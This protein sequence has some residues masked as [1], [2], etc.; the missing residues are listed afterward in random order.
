MSMRHYLRMQAASVRSRFSKGRESEQVRVDSNLPLNLRFG[1]RLQFSEAPFLLAGEASYVSFP[2]NEALIGAFSEV[3]LGGLK[4]FRLY[5]ESRADEEQSAMLM[6]LMSD[7]GDH[8]D[9]MYLFQEQ[10]ELPIYHVSLAEVA[11]HDDETTAVDFWLKDGEGILGMPL[12]HTPDELTYERLWESEQDRWLKPTE[13]SETI[14]L[15]AYGSARTK[16][17]HVGS[18][19]FGRVFEGLGGDVQEY[20]FTSVERDTDGFRVRIWVG[21]PLSQADIDLPDAV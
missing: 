12:F 15:D 18:M 7:S 21:L 3:D 14:M 5:L 2:G 4:T 11:E 9:E 10:Y 17:E 13:S 16:V 1:S 20:L 19:L 8:V 6:V